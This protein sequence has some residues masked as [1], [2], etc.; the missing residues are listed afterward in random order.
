MCLSTV[1]QRT[2]AG[3]NNLLCSNI[4]NVSVEPVSGKLT[5]TDIMGVHY[6]ALGKIESIDLVN[7]VIQLTPEA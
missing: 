6:E 1:Y 7:N 5:F 3:S 2:D 4:Q